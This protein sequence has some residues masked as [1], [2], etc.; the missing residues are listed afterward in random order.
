MGLWEP[1]TGFILTV[2]EEFALFSFSFTDLFLLIIKIM[3]YFCMHHAKGQRACIC[4]C[5]L[6]VGN[7]LLAQA[8]L[9]GEQGRATVNLPF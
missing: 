7:L 2:I 5:T 4:L 1:K 3:T 8:L 9:L 6:V